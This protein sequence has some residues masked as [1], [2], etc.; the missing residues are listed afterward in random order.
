MEQEKAAQRT[1]ISI[2]SSAAPRNNFN[3][4]IP[5]SSIV[6]RTP[7]NPTDKRMPALLNENSG[8]NFVNIPITPNNDVQIRKLP[9]GS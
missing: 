6:P 3:I 7:M 1:N 8:G 4:V 5:G 2:G 9:G